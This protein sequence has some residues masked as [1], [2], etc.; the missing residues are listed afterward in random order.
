MMDVLLRRCVTLAIHV[1]TSNTLLLEEKL[2]SMRST[3]LFVI[4]ACQETIAK[5]S[6]VLT[7]SLAVHHN[8]H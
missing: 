3:H 4:T 6:M 1:C 7:S 8:D 5:C 2:T